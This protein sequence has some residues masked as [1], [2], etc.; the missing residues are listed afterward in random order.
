[1]ENDAGNRL[2]QA[3]RHAI[4]PVSTAKSTI[5]ADHMKANLTA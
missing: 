3:R 5:S 2:K 1:M 4:L